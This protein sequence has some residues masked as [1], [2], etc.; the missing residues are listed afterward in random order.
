MFIK[1]HSNDNSEKSA[2]L[3]HKSSFY[4]SLLTA[5][6]MR[7]GYLPSPSMPLFRFHH[8]FHKLIPLGRHMQA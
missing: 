8:G 1:E 3:R 7:D 4:F 6:M 2:N 5:G